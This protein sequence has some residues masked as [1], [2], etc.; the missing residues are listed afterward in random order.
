MKVVH[1]RWQWHSLIIS[2]AAV[3]GLSMRESWL[4]LKLKLK[5]KRLMHWGNDWTSHRLRLLVTSLHRISNAPKNESGRQKGGRKGAINHHQH[6]DCN[7][8][9]LVYS[10]TLVCIKEKK[11]TKN[12]KRKEL[13]LGGKVQLT[14]THQ[15]QAHSER[16]RFMM[17][18]SRRCSCWTLLYYF[19][20]T[21]TDS[22]DS[23]TS[24]A[25]A[26]TA[27]TEMNYFGCWC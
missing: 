17:E 20:F 14:A 4:T 5:L 23:V 13:D 7:Q 26:T 24:I 18:L 6:F 19:T 10:E 1:W 3:R 2:S 16:A 22:S 8:S 25:A 15:L 11:K 27:E 21:L 12:G 9:L